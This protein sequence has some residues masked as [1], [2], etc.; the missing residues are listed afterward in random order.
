MPHLDKPIRYSLT[1]LPRLLH[2]QIFVSLNP[3]IQPDPAKVHKVSGA[4]WC[5]VRT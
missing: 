3:T 4:L 5:G 2:T 1:D